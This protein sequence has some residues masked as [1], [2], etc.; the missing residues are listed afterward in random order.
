MCIFLPANNDYCKV[1][2]PLF[3]EEHGLRLLLEQDGIGVELSRQSYEAGEWASAV[4]EAYLKGRSMKEAKR[5][6]MRSGIGLGKREEEIK[7]LALEVLGWIR[8]WSVNRD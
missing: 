1:S 6:D 8:D 7:D 5:R 2:R 4:D 3:V